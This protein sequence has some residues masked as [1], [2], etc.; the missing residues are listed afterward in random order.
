MSIDDV[1][2]AGDSKADGA[3]GLLATEDT[4]LMNRESCIIK[5][6]HDDANPPQSTL[7]NNSQNRLYEKLGF[8]RHRLQTIGIIGN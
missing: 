6:D 2:D 8:P 4:E 5:Y 1:T 7:S 3:A